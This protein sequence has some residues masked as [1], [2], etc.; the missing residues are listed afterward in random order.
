MSHELGHNLFASHDGQGSNTCPADNDY[1]MGGG[2]ISNY[3]N[4]VRF[5]PCNV[6]EMKANLLSSDLKFVQLCKILTKIL[7]NS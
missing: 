6:N 2:R 4:N 3:T 1:T 5:S 7:I